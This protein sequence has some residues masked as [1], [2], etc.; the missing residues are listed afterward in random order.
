[1][2]GAASGNPDEVNMKRFILTGA[3]GS[4]K[5]SIL[6]ALAAAGYPVV[7]EAATDV[8]AARLALG[9]AEPW[10]DPRFI[11]RIAALQRQRRAAP[12]SPAA[13]VQVHDRSAVCTLALARHLG[14]PVTPL[15]GAE[16]ARII[17][18]GYFDRRVF[19]VRPLGFIEPTEVRRISYTES[20]AFERVHEAE[21]RRLGFDLVDVP[22]GAVAARAAAVGT[23]ITAWAAGG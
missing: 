1:V 3:P 5:T 22:A 21:Y 13:A 9:Q 8:M 2:R 7:E 18:S 17:S 6:R 15:L 4:G 20:L 11:D 12:V 23:Q 16:V 14:H 10:A 19:F